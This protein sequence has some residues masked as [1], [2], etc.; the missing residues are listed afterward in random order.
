MTV[1]VV[2]ARPL[3]RLAEGADATEVEAATVAEALERLCQV[4]PSLR[5]RVFSATGLRRDLLIFV[6]QRDIR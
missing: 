6:N 3:R 5:E 4:Y 2:L 1:K